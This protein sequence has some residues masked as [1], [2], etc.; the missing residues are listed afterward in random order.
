MPNR[1]IKESI[2][3]S[4]N[5][6]RLTAF[7]ETVF[8]RLMVNCDDYGRMDARPKI[9]ISRLFPL[10]DIR[11]NQIE[12]ALQALSSAELVTLYSVDGKPFLQMTTWER[13]Q[14]IRSAKSK[15]PSPEQAEEHKNEPMISDDIKCN[16]P[17]SDDIKCSRNPIQSESNPNPNTNTE[18][19]ETPKRFRPPTVEEVAEYCK[20][21]KN[22]VNP[23]HFVD[24][25]A[26]KGWIV[27]KA[28]MK[29]WKAAVRNWEH[30]DAAK[31]Q[32]RPQKPRKPM[33]EREL[34]EK[35]F[36]EGYYADIMNRPRAV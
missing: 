35:E 25:Y 1:I 32:A 8:Y 29:D 21:R 12:D 13:H 36:A 20:E 9:L 11:V 26:S 30:E 3:T 7:Q 24:F 31:Q 14:Q 34:S 27:G 22:A 18:T 19:R 15:Y 6:D 28:P 17:L 33:D 16:Q 10:K 23:W 4:E 2:C 5:I